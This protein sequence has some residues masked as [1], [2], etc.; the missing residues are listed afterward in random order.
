MSRLQSPP[1]RAACQLEKVGST[2]GETEATVAAS[3]NRRRVVGNMS[4]RWF[5]GRGPLPFSGIQARSSTQSSRS[6]PTA[7]SSMPA[8]YAT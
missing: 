8:T 6:Q 1:R 4:G 2:S 5:S 3:I 7:T